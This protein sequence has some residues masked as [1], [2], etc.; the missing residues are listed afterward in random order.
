MAYCQQQT[1]TAD[2]DAGLFPSQRLKLKDK[3]YRKED[4]NIFFTGLVVWT[5]RAYNGK[6]T[7]PNHLMAD[8]ICAR[9]ARNYPKYRNKDSL[10]TYNF[11]Q[12][13]PSRH[14][15]NDPYFSQKKK[16]QLPDDL[17]DTS[18]L[19]LSEN[20]G[21]SLNHW[22][23]HQM[24]LHANRSKKTIH[25]T[26]RKYKHLIAYNTWFG[27]RMPVDF[28]I[29]VQANALRFVLDKRLELDEHDLETIHLIRDMVIANEHLK[30]P[31]YISPHYQNTSI[32][33]YHLARLVAAHP[34]HH[35]LQEI[36]NKLIQ[37]I[38]QQKKVVT[39]PMEKLL[40]STSLLRFDIPCP[41]E[42]SIVQKDFD[43]FYFFIANMTSTL[44]NPFKRWFLH[45]K[46]TKFYY[47]S[48]G[49]YWCLVWE[50][51]MLQLP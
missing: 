31:A 21:D 35:G 26:H 40:L 39:H 42:K 7:L 6:L 16:Y 8:T 5:L 32:I 51:E 20:H 25:S 30:E 44:P 3:E 23:K 36:R 47:Q 38:Q 1:T 43:G 10:W 48:E 2:Y 12:T 14:F 17:D 49:Y 19:Y 24:A 50:N 27:K 9:G 15:P 28:D 41:L 33:L 46:K 45:S 18:I 4:N 22:L 29:C 37:D 11:W 13:R 34:E